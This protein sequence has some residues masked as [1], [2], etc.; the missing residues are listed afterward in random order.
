MKNLLLVFALAI[1]IASC[2]KQASQ[3]LAPVEKSVKGI[4][5]GKEAAKIKPYELTFLQAGKKKLQV[6]ST[7]ASISLS[8]TL[9]SGT[10]VCTYDFGGASVAYSTLERRYTDPSGNVQTITWTDDTGGGGG[11]VSGLLPVSSKACTIFF[12]FH[13]AYHSL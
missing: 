10:I 12:A 3:P 8:A 1:T 4:I 5:T 2:T 6:Q 9:S 13:F 11:G 7:T